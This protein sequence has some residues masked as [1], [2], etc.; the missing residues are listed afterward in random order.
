MKIGLVRERLSGTGGAERA[1]REIVMALSGLGH[2]VHV[3]SLTLPGQMRD[4]VTWHQCPPLRRWPRARRMVQFNRWL[5]SEAPAAKVYFL[6]SIGP[7]D[8]TDVLRTGDGVW[9]EW[10]QICLQ[11]L[12][13]WRVALT[14]YYRTKLRQEERVF[15]PANTRL[16][17]SVSHMVAREILKY[18]DYPPERIKVIYNGVDQ[19]HFRPLSGDQKRLL[20]EQKGFAG[21]DFIVLFSGAGF[22]RKGADRALEIMA[23]W[24][25]LSNRKLHFVLVGKAENRSFEQLAARLKV[26]NVSFIGPVP[27]DAMLQWYQLSDLFLLPARY[28]PIANVCLEANACGVPVAAS[29]TTGFFELITPINGLILE[30]DPLQNARQLEL[31]CRQLPDAETVRGAVAHLTWESYIQQIVEALEWARQFPRPSGLG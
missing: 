3:F 24:Q 22:W 17:I 27:P 13:R 28:D 31:Y 16:V 11:H 7:Y 21:D 12:P 1:A 29:T 14:P 26:A 15:N 20:R 18:Y 10:S 2:E 23:Q 5:V 19:T 6:L 30:D 4:K 8:L 25:A 9:R